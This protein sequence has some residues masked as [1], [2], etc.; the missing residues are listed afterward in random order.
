MTLPPPGLAT[1]PRGT[2]GPTLGEAG[3][4]GRACGGGPT[5]PLFAPVAVELAIEL[6]VAFAFERGEATATPLPPVA[7]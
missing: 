3:L 2:A 7:A 5:A 1:E 4:R 6:P